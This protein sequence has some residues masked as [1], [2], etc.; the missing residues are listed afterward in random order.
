[1]NHTHAHLTRG[2]G[3][4]E[5]FLAK[6]RAAMANKLIPTKTRKGRILDV[7]CGSFPHFLL[8]TKFSEKHGVD[9]MVHEKMIPLQMKDALHLKKINLHKEK[10]N[11]KENY[12]DVIVML[13]VLE[14]I[15]RKKL[16]S[17]LKNI[18]RMLKKGG[19][20][21][22]TTPSP[23]STGVLWALSRTFLISKEEIDDHKELLGSKEILGQLQKASFLKKNI[24]QGYFELGWNMW[25][26]ARK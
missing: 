4:F 1:M 13:A 10:I 12:F 17:L 26:I 8:S 6:K 16:P 22:M 3:L 5:T 9:L 23:W 25:F 11:Y 20:L 15:D 21:I 7:G 18:N 24:K 14:H 19:V 2:F